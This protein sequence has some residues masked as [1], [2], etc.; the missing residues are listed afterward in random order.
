[1]ETIS[2]DYVR[3]DNLLASMTPGRK[4]ERSSGPGLVHQRPGIVHHDR[5]VRK[6]YGQGRASLIIHP[7]RSGLRACCQRACDAKTQKPDRK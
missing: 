6:D 5:R 3:S 7:F 4:P 1:M 2:I